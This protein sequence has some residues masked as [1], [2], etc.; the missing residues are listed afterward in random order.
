MA[1]AA[2]SIDSMLTGASHRGRP[3]LL[4]LQRTRVVRA[5]HRRE[6]VA[7][8]APV[9][10]RQPPLATAA[11]HGARPRAWTP[12]DADT[13]PPGGLVHQHRLRATRRLAIAP[14]AAR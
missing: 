7:V 8:T 14:P 9:A 10:Q 5:P 1:R 6:T 2:T 3:R 12:V 13:P 4:Y 11:A